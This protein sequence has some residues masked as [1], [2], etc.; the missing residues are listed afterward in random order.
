[1][2]FTVETA[3]GRALAIRAGKNNH[4]PVFVDLDKLATTKGKDRIKFLKEEADRASLSA[5]VAKAVEAA[6]NVADMASA[7]DPIVDERGSPKKHEIV[8][9]T[10]IRPTSAAAPAAT[11]RRAA[12]PNRSCAM[13]W[14]RRSRPKSATIY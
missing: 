8:A 2:G 6:N 12:S 9:G 11:I 3:A 1:M 10:P 7:L 14:S 5:N 4:T 13:R